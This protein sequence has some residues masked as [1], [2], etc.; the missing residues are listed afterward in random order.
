MQAIA[1]KGRFGA[2]YGANLVLTLG[3]LVL[4]GMIV[5]LSHLPFEQS[6]YIV[7]LSFLLVHYYHDHFLFTRFGELARA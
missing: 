4:I 7:V 5:A 6:Y 1:A 2:F 3:A